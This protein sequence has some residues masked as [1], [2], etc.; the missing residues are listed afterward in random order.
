MGGTDG[1]IDVPD[2]EVE[3]ACE[4]GI[5]SP[6]GNLDCCMSG[7]P[8][9]GVLGGVGGCPPADGDSVLPCK[10]AESIPGANEALVL[11]LGESVNDEDAGGDESFSNIGKNEKKS[12]LK[13]QRKAINFNPKDFPVRLYEL[14]YGYH[15]LI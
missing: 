11:E 13:S 1:C 15:R 8:D 9:L 7:P 12:R 4:E 14:N 2:I 3:G 6:R 5:F 10:A